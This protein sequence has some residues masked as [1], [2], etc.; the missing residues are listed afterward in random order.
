MRSFSPGVCANCGYM[1]FTADEK[2]NTPDELRKLKKLAL[3]EKMHFTS[4]PYT[5][6]PQC[7]HEFPPTGKPESV[8]FG[9]D[10]VKEHLVYVRCVSQAVKLLKDA[11]KGLRDSVEQLESIGTVLVNGISITDPKQ[12][13]L[14]VQPSKLTF[15]I[16]ALREEA[17][18]LES[19]VADAIADYQERKNAKYAGTKTEPA[20]SNQA[21]NDSA[22]TVEN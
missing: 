8:K 9:A 6:C 10:Q 19:N 16:E 14:S 22:G 13:D 2:L 1:I 20:S 21:G 11:S 18:R 17:V 5:A 4:K 3:S 7:G 12:I 15:A